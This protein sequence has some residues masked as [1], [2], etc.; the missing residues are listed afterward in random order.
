M[1]QV[2]H[3]FIWKRARIAI[4][5]ASNSELPDNFHTALGTKVAEECII[6]RQARA[7]GLHE[8]KTLRSYTTGIY[9]DLF[10]PIY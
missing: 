2:R 4:N 1:K 3:R 10:S 5:V 9:R 6:L 7:L 8:C